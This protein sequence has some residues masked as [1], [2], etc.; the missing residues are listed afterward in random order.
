MGLLNVNIWKDLEL[1]FSL[2]EHGA[3]TLQWRWRF[4]IVTNTL[5]KFDIADIR[6]RFIDWY[7][8]GAYTCDGLFDIGNATARALNN[9]CD[10]TDEYSNGNGSLMRTVPLAFTNATDA[11]IEE[12]SAITHAHITSRKC[13]VRMVH[14]ARRLISGNCP[15]KVL[16]D[17]DFD[18]SKQERDIKSGGFVLDTFEAS[19]WCLANTSSYSECVLKA[20]NLGN[21][22]DTTG[23]VA[24]ALAGIVYGFDAIPATWI[25]TLRGKEIIDDCLF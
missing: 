10:L 20:V 1:I 9:G 23:A 2:L 13:C 8:N 6:A 18:Y 25:E 5:V 12:V 17:I 14:I 22:T 3:T 7:K 16:D 15:Q 19:L 24:G 4:V 11:E 21:D